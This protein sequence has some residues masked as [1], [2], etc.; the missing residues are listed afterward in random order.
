MAINLEEIKPANTTI[1]DIHFVIDRKEWW[2]KDPKNEWI[3]LD[4][5]AV[6]RHLA[7]KYKLTDPDKQNYFLHELQMRDHSDCAGN[8]AGY[9]KSGPQTVDTL[10]LLVPRP[11]QLPEVRQGNWG[12]LKNFIDGLFIDPDQRSA[13]YGWAQCAVR[14]LREGIPGEWSPGQALVLIGDSGVGKTSLQR[15]I[16]KLLTGRSADPDRYFIGDTTF[17]GE[18]GSNEHWLI[19]D[20]TGTTPQGKKKFMKHFKNSVANSVWSINP[21]NKGAVNLPIYKRVTISLNSDEESMSVLP[22][23]E[24]SYLEKLLLLDCAASTFRPTGKEWA[25]WI[26]QVHS[27]IGACLY[28]LLY[29]FKVP[30][31]LF[32]VRYGVRYHNKHWEAKTAAPSQEQKEASIDELMRS[33]L[34]A[35]RTDYEGNATN[36]IELLHGRN[37]EHAA[38]AKYSGIS[39]A[40]VHLGRLLTGWSNTNGGRRNGFKISRNG[41][42]GSTSYIFERTSHDS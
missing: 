36:I 18:L 13:F 24:P 2:V 33:A 9:L 30:E 22:L 3:P 28:H 31:H 10:R 8:Y 32:D 37:S 19:S 41:N 39:Q 25:L 5:S 20:P 42:N 17:N 16:T 27:E 38:A 21:K 26:D 23:M 35:G 11:C 34:L 12:T 14:T 40:P 7:I 4:E 29:Q 6:R 15:I 1:D